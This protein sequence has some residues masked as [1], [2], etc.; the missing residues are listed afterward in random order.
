M[1]K[2]W[3]AAFATAIAFN[4]LQAQI[5]GTTIEDQKLMQPYLINNL[6]TIEHQSGAAETIN[7]VPMHF[8]LVGDASGAGKQPE[9]K[10]LDLLCDMNDAYAPMNLR[11]YLKKH[12]TYGLFDYTINNAGVYSDQTNTS[13]MTNRRNTSAIN[14]YVVNTPS[15][16]NNQPGTV[17]AY[18]NPQFDW[19]VCRKS[20]A[21]GGKN[22]TLPHETGHFFSL[23]HTFFGY[24]SN[25][26]DPTDAGWPIAPLISPGG[27]PTEFQNGSN[28]SSAA[29]MICDTP[30]DYN[31]G[32]TQGD[33]NTYT[34]GAEDPTGTPVVP[35]EK[36]FMSYFIG[37]DYV[38][39]AMQQAAVLADYATIHRNYI[40]YSF[41]PAA[42]DITT[43]AGMLV[44][45]T[46]GTIASTYDQVNFEWQAVTGA[47][48]YLLE[49]D[50]TPSFGSPLLQEFIVTG[51]TK[52]VTTLQKNKTY[53]WRVRPFNEYVTC[54]ANSETNILKTNDVSA[55]NNIQDVQAWQI[56]PNPVAPGAPL[57]MAITTGNSIQATISILNAE[58]QLIFNQTNIQF[59][60]GE[61]AM[62]LP[63]NNLNNGIYFVVLENQNGREVRKL[64]V[65]R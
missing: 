26:F 46:A 4:A 65:I 45:P 23:M 29:D 32:F 16:G 43:P 3:M 21:Q 19:I 10:I 17:L 35:M 54:A 13:L 42:T 14:V 2:I 36:N 15:N 50:I 6:Q 56:S 41:T 22:G 61:S 34:A 62:D 55:V 58:G 20:Q 18:F 40:H 38:F 28:C 30:P 1:K 48:Y 37:C 52:L 12:P 53:Y 11:F 39:T 33:C 5:C 51:T 49:T 31:F 60:E 59:P 8:H 44:S 63:T 27:A 25:P 7:Y 24:E 47:T 9:R 57:R 64:S